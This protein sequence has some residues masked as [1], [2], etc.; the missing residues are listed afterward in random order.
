MGKFRQMTFALV[1]AEDNAYFGQ[2]RQPKKDMTLE[3]VSS[4]LLSV[5][6]GE[7][8]P[9]WGAHTTQLSRADDSVAPSMY[10]KYSKLVHHDVFQEHKILHLI[11]ASFLEKAKTME[12]LAKNPHRNIVRYHGCRVRR[13]RIVGLVLDRHPTTLAAL[14]EQEKWDNLKKEPFLE[15]L[16]SGI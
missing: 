4:A 10:I 13:G 6:D 2:S 5:P 3:Q 1:D 15:A 8:F 7:I 11:S 9:D 14:L 12:I 16:S